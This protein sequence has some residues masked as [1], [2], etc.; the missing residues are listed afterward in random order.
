VEPLEGKCEESDVAI[1]KFPMWYTPPVSVKDRW[2]D[3]REQVLNV[4]IA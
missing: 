2:V 1:L 4:S 3:T